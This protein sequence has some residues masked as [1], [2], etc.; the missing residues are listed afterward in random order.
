MRFL[1]GR[2]M[3]SQNVLVIMCL[4]PSALQW[5]HSLIA[6][7]NCTCYI[8]LFLDMI[9]TFFLISDK[10]L[11]RIH[12]EFSGSPLFLNRNP[13]FVERPEILVTQV[14]LCNGCPYRGRLH[15]FVFPHQCVFK[16]CIE[17]EF[18][19]SVQWF[20]ISCVSAIYRFSWRYKYFT[21]YNETELKI[22]VSY[23]IETR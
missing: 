15:S 7:E 1:A 11:G 5:R 3:R 18:K 9:Q 14:E 10:C 16:T 2:W 13:I 17:G 4:D 12:S 19:L 6:F 8:E 20:S 23:N 22:M 21:N